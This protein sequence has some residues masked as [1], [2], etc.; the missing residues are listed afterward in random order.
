MRYILILILL[1]LSTF[2]YCVGQ[3]LQGVSYR[4]LY[5]PA[6][7]FSFDWKITRH[8]TGW[9]ASYALSV[10]DTS[11]NIYAILWETRNTVRDES[12]KILETPIQKRKG[13]L[14]F[15]KDSLQQLLVAKVVNLS[16]KKAWYFYK[17]L[18]PNYPQNFSFSVSDS[19]NMKPFLLTNSSIA[20][21]D[22]SGAHATAFYYRQDFPPAAPPFSE[23]LSR[24]SAAM[25][26]DSTFMIYANQEI[27]LNQ[28][29]LYLFQKDTASTNGV[30]FR[31]EEDYPKYRTIEN[32]IGPIQYICTKQEYD[33]LLAANGDKKAFDKVI[34]GITGNKERAKNFMRSYFTNVE[35]AN[36]YFTSYKEGWKTDRGMIFIIL[37][38]PTIIYKFQDRE[39]WEYK[40]ALFNHSFTFI[41]SSTVFDPENYVL[42]R[43]NKY[44]LDWYQIIDLWR[45]SRF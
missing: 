13:Q 33:K 40:T 36:R 25:N 24:V 38:L 17:Y 7:P 28:K 12:G 11:N 3:E 45:K 26:S 18:D 35:L 31:V 27:I 42:I 41:R 37:G 23:S 2:D 44:Q 6:T 10:S 5:D 1:F 43:D 39:V 20:L 9:K 30:A 16:E 14:Y 29:G 22:D 34:L 15:P 4:Y 19:S 8:L 32:L 21:E